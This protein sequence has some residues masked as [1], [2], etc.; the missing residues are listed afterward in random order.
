MNQGQGQGAPGGIQGGPGG[1]AP[2]WIP[3]DH[4][5]ASFLI[6]KV[7]M[8]MDK[9]KVL[10]SSQ[11][12]SRVPMGD[13]LIRWVDMVPDFKVTKV[14]SRTRVALHNKVILVDNRGSSN[15]NMEDMVTIKAII[16]NM[17]NLKVI[18]SRDQM[19][20]LI[21]LTMV[22]RAVKD[23]PT[24]GDPIDKMIA[25]KVLGIIRTT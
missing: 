17:A 21:I 20:I 15:A 19:I 18:D 16:N 10:V 4:N 6:N 11:A 25:L 24:E 23:F 5:L 2:G 3:G 12:V 1:L 9:T 22:H 7:D 8:V 13:L 14:S